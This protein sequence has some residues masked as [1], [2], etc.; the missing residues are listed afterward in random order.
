MKLENT[1]DATIVCTGNVMCDPRMS[2]RPRACQ[3]K[4]PHP[5]FLVYVF[6]YMHILYVFGMC[7]GIENI[8]I[9]EAAL[10]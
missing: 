4:Y 5:Q 10:L 7:T 8:A 2:I 3:D 6:I 9:T 1:T